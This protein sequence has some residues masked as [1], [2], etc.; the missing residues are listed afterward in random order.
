[1]FDDLDCEECKDDGKLL[2]WITFLWCVALVLYYS[3]R[4]AAWLVS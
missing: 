3:Y 1:M 4:F 2:G